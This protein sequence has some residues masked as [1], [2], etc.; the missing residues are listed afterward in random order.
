MVFKRFPLSFHKDAMPASQASLCAQDQGKF[1]EMHDHIFANQKALKG[2]QTST[3]VEW[4]TAAGVKNSA[5]FKKCLE[6]GAKKAQVEA[7]MAE[8]RKSGV[9]GTPSV[10]INGRKFTSPSGYNVNAFKSVID[11]YILKKK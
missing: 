11:K 1:W 10:Y 3:L 4:A 8:G 2:I 6:S 9:R 7:E 5:K